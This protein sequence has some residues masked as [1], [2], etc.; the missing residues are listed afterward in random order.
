MKKLMALLAAGALSLTALTA[1]GGSDSGGSTADGDQLNVGVELFPTSLEPSYAWDSWYSIRF[2]AAETLV[3]YD[4]QGEIIP[5]LA[6]SWEVA[7]DELTWTFKLH[8]GVKFSNG[9]DM[10][11]TSVK[12]SI[13]RLYELTDT[14]NGGEGLP[15]AHFTYSSITADDAANTVTIV[16]DEPQPDMLGCMAYPW[17]MIIDVEATDADGRDVSTQGPIATGPYAWESYTQNSDAQM[18]RNEY[19]WDGDVP[20]ARVNI[21][22]VTEATTRS[23]GLQD[24]SLD[25]A[26]NISTA[27]QS[28]LESTGGFTI[29]EVTGSRTG[30]AHVNFSGPLGNDALRQAVLMAIDSETIAESTTSGAYSYGYAIIPSSLD[31]G[32]DELTPKFTFDADEAVKVLDAAGITDTDGDGYRELDGEN[33]DLSYIVTSNRQMD[34]IAQAQAAELAEIGIKVTVQVVQTQAEYMNSHQ[35]DLVSSNEVT[36]QTGDPSKFMG[37]WRTDDENNFSLYSNPEYD[38]L[39]DQMV[40]EF[41]ADKRKEYIKQM[42]QILIDDAAVIVYGYFKYNITTVDTLTGVNKCPNDFYWVVKDIQTTS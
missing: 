22:N 20:F 13:E 23:L 24:G 5:W 38:A 4:E 2:G 10:T 40:V 39:Y 29:N 31:Y 16:T 34:T 36:T 1:C 33:I 17:M 28:V 32:Y 37:H 9:N 19:Y 18:V 12:E 41:D 14:A 30:F 21:R 26:L 11:A 25:M 3:R 27:D 42:Q 7:D 15:Q 8:E 35:F 6:D